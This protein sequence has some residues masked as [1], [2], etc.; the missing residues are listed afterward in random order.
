MHAAGEGGVEEGPNSDAGAAGD[1][2]THCNSDTE[3]SDDLRC[4][5]EES[6][7]DGA[8]RAGTPSACSN[9]AKCVEDARLAPCAYPDASPWLA[10]VAD[11]DTPGLE[12]LYAV[13]E[14]LIGV[15]QPIKL[16]APLPVS[17]GKTPRLY[18]PAWTNDG[19]WLVYGVVLDEQWSALR[20]Y[21]VGFDAGTPSAAIEL[22]KDLP[23]GQVYLTYPA[24]GPSASPNGNSVL[25][26]QTNGDLYRVDL[27]AKGASAPLRLNLGTETVQSGEWVLGGTAVAYTTQSQ[28]LLV[29]P[30]G[31]GRE[32]FA[33]YRP[34]LV[35]VPPG[36]G[37]HLNFI[38]Q[39]T[40]D[41]YIAKV[42][43]GE[44]IVKVNDTNLG[45][46]VDNRFSPDGQYVTYSEGEKLAGSRKVY[47]LD[48][49]NSPTWSR[50]K[51]LDGQQLDTGESLG[52]WAP[53]SSYFVFF[54]DD[55]YPD[56]KDVYV[57]EAASGSTRK[58]PYQIGLRD[59]VL[60]FASPG[61]FLISNQRHA[62]DKVELLIVGPSGSETQLHTNTLG[63]PY[64]GAEV[65]P[66]GSGAVFCAGAANEEL[67]YVDLR[68]H[69]FRQ[70]VM[71]P[72]EGSAYGCAD[73]FASDSKGFVYYRAALD[74]SRTLYWAD[75]T[76][77]VLA[78]PV[79]VTRS[80]RAR[81]WT[82]QPWVTQAR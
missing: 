38:D 15:Q 40:Y 45:D 59:S 67:Y 31:S 60:G 54:G 34:T 3:C 29:N 35:M 51:L 82:W 70:A 65:A 58:L 81:I 44:A 74:G 73:G 64:Q 49:L 7:V 46:Y 71:L 14:S 56:R 42:A 4:N 20:W 18:S 28:A 47:L 66:D 79:P 68:D 2:L 50:K 69:S 57:S 25:L 8:C 9:E 61:N 53:D 32:A 48:L 22:T 23:L 16:N 63:K 11:E 72:G 43:P 77:Q 6:C 75:T 12:E 36:N 52:P 10:Y 37:S 80:G 1:G 62:S 5:G 26:S 33:G 21:A 13:K 17:P 30:D 39:Q 19:R 55:D 24:F 41:F 27:T 78:R 76:H